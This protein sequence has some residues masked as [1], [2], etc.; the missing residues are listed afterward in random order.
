MASKQDKF[1]FDN[2]VEAADSSCQA[3]NY[4]VECLRTYDYH[5]I[6]KMLQ[7]MHEYEHAGDE[8]RHAMF[9]ALAKAFVTPIDREDLALISKNLDD[10][11]DSV[12]DVLQSFYMNHITSVLPAAMTFAGNILKACEAIK[13]ILSEF[14]NYKKHAAFH[15]LIIKLNDIEEECD[16]LYLEARHSLRDQFSNTWDIVA[17][18]EIF[19]K[20][21]DCADTCEHVGDSISTVIMKNS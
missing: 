3:A 18:R 14:Q 8:T 12:E 7:K 11:T 10:V 1:Y 2:L 13:E 15:K 5:N 19:D 20:M 21:E 6:D 9:T 17:W 4:L 16:R